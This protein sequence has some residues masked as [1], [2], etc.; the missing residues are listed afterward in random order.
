M[1]VMYTKGKGLDLEMELP[2]LKPCR[3]PPSS[4][5]LCNK[6][7]EFVLWKKAIEKQNSAKGLSDYQSKFPFVF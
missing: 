4:P 1:V 2:Y 3:I 6:D 7:V 5:S